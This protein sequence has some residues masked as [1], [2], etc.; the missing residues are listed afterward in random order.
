MVQWSIAAS[1]IGSM[2]HVAAIRR[3]VAA[4]RRHITYTKT[5]TKTCGSYTKDDEIIIEL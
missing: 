5:Y 2:W 3:H 4:I 1:E